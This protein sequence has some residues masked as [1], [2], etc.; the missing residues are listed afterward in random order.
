[1]HNRELSKPIDQFHL[2]SNHPTSLGKFVRSCIIW[3]Q[4]N[5]RV[6]LYHKIHNNIYSLMTASAS[7]FVVNFFMLIEVE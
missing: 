6:L 3:I 1:M 2:E 5:S 4:F 7:D